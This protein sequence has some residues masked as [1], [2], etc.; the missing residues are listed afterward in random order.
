M[1]ALCDIHFIDA[2]RRQIENS[3]LRLLQYFLAHE[4]IMLI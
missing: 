3:M 4:S 2:P 1:R